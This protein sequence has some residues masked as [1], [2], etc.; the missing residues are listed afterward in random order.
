MNSRRIFSGLTVALLFLFIGSIMYLHGV[1]TASGVTYLHKKCTSA[2]VVDTNNCTVTGS[3][4]GTCSGNFI[5]EYTNGNCDIVENGTYCTPTGDLSP[6]TRNYSCGWSGTVCTK[7]GSPS[8]SGTY[9]S[10]S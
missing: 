8:E 5:S 7:Y 9:Q 1:Q 6:K 4:P 2:T 10:C 3:N